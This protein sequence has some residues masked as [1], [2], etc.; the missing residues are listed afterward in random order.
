MFL[1]QQKTSFQS[2]NT[3][4]L[5]IRKNRVINMEFEI[6]SSRV[7]QN[8]TWG[9]QEV[10]A[11]KKSN[12]LQSL[13]SAVIKYF[14]LS[15]ILTTRLFYFISTLEKESRNGGVLSFCSFLGELLLKRYFLFNIVFQVF[16][17]KVM[18]CM[19]LKKHL[20]QSF[21][22]MVESSSYI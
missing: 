6:I 11:D 14:C 15:L 3:L 22:Q 7:A 4:Q 20:G 5:K 10:V 21:F 12:Q 9:N 2:P 16:L 19:Q 1:I 17:N 13:V 18:P 8:W